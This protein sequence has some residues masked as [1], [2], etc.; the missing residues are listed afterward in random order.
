[1]WI[2]LVTAVVVFGLGL[3]LFVR[4]INI[5]IKSSN[6]M[7]TNLQALSG[8]LCMIIGIGLL[9]FALLFTSIYQT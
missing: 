2:L 6:F 7:E 3:F 8:I 9:I 4:S 1:M 5:E